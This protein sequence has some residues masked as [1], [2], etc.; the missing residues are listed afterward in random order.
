MK[1]AQLSNFF[2][3]NRSADEEYRYFFTN[4]VYLVFFRNSLHGVP[5]NE[6]NNFKNY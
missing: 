6:K 3:K 1:Q 2:T 4:I 5:R